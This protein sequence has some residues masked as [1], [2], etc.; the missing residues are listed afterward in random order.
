M[1]LNII[2]GSKVVFVCVKFHAESDPEV[3]LLLNDFLV[4]QNEDF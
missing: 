2:L 3:R 4:L 1:T